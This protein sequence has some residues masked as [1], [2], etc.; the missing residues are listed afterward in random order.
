M[1]FCKKVETLDGVIQRELF[2][3]SKGR[4]L[5]YGLVKQEKKYCQKKLEKSEIQA[6]Q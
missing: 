3:V 4:Y 1:Y 5:H 6:E 2:C